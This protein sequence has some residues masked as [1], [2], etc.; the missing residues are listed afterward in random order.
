MKLD[1]TL[2]ILHMLA[3]QSLNLWDIPNGATTRLI[4]I[5]ENATYLVEAP[6][7]RAILRVHRENYHNRIAIESE[8]AW[9]TALQAEA[10]IDTPDVYCGRNGKRVQSGWINGLKEPRFMVL[11]HFIDGPH[12]N[13]KADL[14]GQFEKLGEIAARTHKHSTTWTRPNNFKRLIWDSEAVFGP[15]PLW[16]NWHAA[17][18]VTPTINSLLHE[19]ETLLRAR[20]A[21]F[22]QGADRFGLIHADMRLANLIEHRDGPRLIDFD[23]C[24][25]GWY[26]YDFAAAISFFEDNKTIPA[27]R[28]AWVAGYRKIR[29]V[30]AFEEYEI[31]TFVMLRRMALLAWIGSHIEAPEP[32]A[33]APDFA[34][35]TAELGRSYLDTMQN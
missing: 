32:Q 9:M 11:F 7:Y 21:A 5:S 13:E 29:P 22:G 27:L 33:L 12:P 4:N 15:A 2:K 31:G 1:E 35:V 8:L 18:G 17:P 28:R 3:N 24:G 6:D 34:R 26:L 16:G 23:D 19:V 14:T 10:N 25:L 30:D 20:L